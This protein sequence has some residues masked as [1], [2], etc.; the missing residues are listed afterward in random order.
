MPAAQEPVLDDIPSSW[1]PVEKAEA[2]EAAQTSSEGGGLGFIGSLIAEEVGEYSGPLPVS[3]AAPVSSLLEF[4]MAGFTPDQVTL[5]NRFREDYKDLKDKHYFDILGIDRS[6]NTAQ[7]QVA[8]HKMMKKYH[9]DVLQGKMGEL[10]EPLSKLALELFQLA[11]KSYD[12]LSNAEE[13][14]QYVSSVFYG[15]QI[16]EEEAAVAKVETVLKAD[17]VFKKGIGMLN[18]GHLRGAH[19]LFQKAVDMYGEEPEYQACL[20]YT[21]FKLNYPKNADTWEAAEQRVLDAIKENPKSDRANYFMGQISLAKKK[22]KTARKYFVRA[23]K[24]NPRNVDAM[25]E[26]QKLKNATPVEEKGVISSFFSR[27]K[28]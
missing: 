2:P 12:T 17:A 21:T 22:P 10:P 7:V 23:V 6:A 13:R 18:A 25:R 9:P 15:K 8:Y 19:N 26:Y 16:E 11:Q 1:P 27:F 4:S 14:E 5:A 20:G 28:K 24:A 3:K